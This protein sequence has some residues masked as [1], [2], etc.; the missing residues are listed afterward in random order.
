MILD[1]QHI[2]NKFFNN[3]FKKYKEENEIHRYIGHLFHITPYD[4]GEMANLIPQVS[5]GTN[6]CVID[7]TIE[8]QRKQKILY[9]G[10]NA[11]VCFIM[12]PDEVFQDNDKIFIYKSINEEIGYTR[13]FMIESYSEIYC[14]NTVLMKQI[15]YINNS[16]GA[17]KIARM[18]RDSMIVLEPKRANEITHE[19]LL[20]VLEYV[21][22]YEGEIY[23]EDIR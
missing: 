23:E 3:E 9:C 10:M 21:V 1:I 17:V 2:Y 19:Y 13:E 5:K 22:L 7:G 18:L 16:S 4:L 11:C 6:L 14:F 12:A 8:P 20:K 15:G